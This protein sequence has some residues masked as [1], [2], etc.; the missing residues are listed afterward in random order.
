MELEFTGER[1]VPGRVEPELEL[2]HVARYH[3]AASLVQDKK[4]LDLGCGTGYGAAILRRGGAARLL[5][6]DKD[7]GAIAYA[8]RHF[9]A[10]GPRFAVSDGRELAVRSGSVDVVVAFELIEHVEDPHAL[11]A[12][13]A[14]VLRPDGILIASTP[15]AETYRREIP[16]TPANPFHVKE[17]TR[18]EFQGLLEESFDSVRLFGQAITEGVIFRAVDEEAE[19]SGLEL[20]AGPV[21]ES[22]RSGAP[23][24]YVAV[25]GRGAAAPELSRVRAHLHAAE[26]NAV[27]ER[28]LRIV[29]LQ[30]ELQERAEWIRS[31][32]SESSDRRER[33]KQLQEELRERTEFLQSVEA[34]ST[35]RGARLKELQEE[36]EERTKFL[37]SVE[38]ESARRGERL[39]KLQGELEERTEWALSLKEEADSRGSKLVEI[40]QELDERTRWAQSLQRELEKN[41][42]RLQELQDTLDERSRIARKLQ[43]ETD[44]RDRQFLARLSQ[45]DSLA[46]WSARAQEQSELLRREVG[47]LG[48]ELRESLR[49]SGRQQA[50]LDEV[51]DRVAWHRGSLVEQ[52]AR[53]EEAL[54]RGAALEAR[55]EHAEAA[56]YQHQMGLDH[57]SDRLNLVNRRVDE[58]EDSIRQ[59]GDAASAL[60]GNVEGLEELVL[61][62]WHGQPARLLRTLRRRWRRLL[63]RRSRTAEELVRRLQAGGVRFDRVADPRVSV[64]VLAAEGLEAMA[65]SLEMLSQTLPETP[66]EVIAVGVDPPDDFEYVVGSVPNLGCFRGGRSGLAALAAAA[67]S[68]RADHVLVVDGDV[69]LDASTVDRLLE[70]F[71]VLPEASMVS[72]RLEA[73]DAG[74]VVFG[75]HSTP[76]G[77]VW[78]GIGEDREDPRFSFAQRVDRVLGGCLMVR[79]D[80]L[81]AATGS[82]EYGPWSVA[83]AAQLAWRAERMDR[84]VF[85]QAMASARCGAAYVTRVKRAGVQTAVSSEEDKAVPAALERGS[86]RPRLLI[87]DHRLP[88]PDRDAGSVRMMHLIELLQAEDVDVTFVPENLQSLEPYS[89]ELRLRGVELITAPLYASIGDFLEQAAPRFDLAMVSRF[90]IAEDFLGLLRQHFGERKVLF[91]TVDLQSL[92][93]MR[94]AR[95]DADPEALRRA[96]EVRDR[97][98]AVARLADAVI[99]VSEFEQELLRKELPEVPTHL[100]SIV[101]DMPGRGSGFLKRRD[102]FFV[103]G[104]EHPPNVDAATWFVHEVLPLIHRRLPKLRLSLIGSN[105]TPEVEALASDRVT[106][107]GFVPDMEPY[108]ESCRLSVAPLRYGAGV[109]GKVNQSLAHGLPCV[110]TSI[111]A[112]GMYLEHGK[113]AMIADSAADFAAAVVKAY[114]SPWLWHR[115]SRRGLAAVR[116]RFSVEAAARSVADLLDVV[117]PDRRDRGRG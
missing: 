87:L 29:E 49:R 117:I 10:V 114:R 94:L 6:V 8:T 37:Q 115:L 109:K 51:E 75:G 38:S 61:R 59:W 98:F 23:A 46:T 12:E 65:T 79:R 7:A 113:S 68:V 116:E 67:Q 39:Q 89:T 93:E 27:R 104:F 17:Y 5:G 111:A 62:L 96:S 76:E 78:S 66:A 36:L 45:L 41:S 47:E 82:A 54:T 110:M 20:S 108:L 40:Q 74:L 63:G 107:T 48:A 1:M 57:H 28:T 31:I 72:A 4:V 112:E 30:G 3:F 43:R 21:D 14:R 13:A 69:R 52:A 24:F 95:L 50:L 33:L 77:T 2:E 58:L 15:N 106:V 44:E 84:R 35:Q 97:E 70:S 91:D 92:R 81:A 83:G 34:E 25:C 18:R 103:G 55:L 100:L 60:A 53:I 73:D 80:L 86:G 88:T 11:L 16:G 99:V 42:E 90:H 26:V 19:R 64:L 22:S 102:L 85:V 105:P 71:A 32:E 56:S 9:A 101:H